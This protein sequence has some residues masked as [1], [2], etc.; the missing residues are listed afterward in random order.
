[1]KRL[2][3]LVLVMLSTSVMSKERIISIGPDI[4]EI[5][6]QLG[7]GDELVGRDMRSIYPPQAANLADVG[8]MRTLNAEGLLSL[9]PDKI[10]ASQLAA[11]SVVFEQIESMGIPV[12]FISGEPSINGMINRIQQVAKA[13]E[14]ESQGGE[15]VKQMQATLA[16]IPSTKL[17]LNVMFIRSFNNNN[18]LAAGKETLIDYVFQIAGVNN[19]LADMNRY[20]TLSGE[21]L[22]LAKPD[23]IVTTKTA[24]RYFQNEEDFWLLDNVINTP[25]GKNRQ[26]LVMDDMALLSFGLQTPQAILFLRHYAE[27]LVASQ[28][29]SN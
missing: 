14:R 2:L 3:F 21:G 18:I 22:I 9:Y 6:Y 15:L 1:M 25:A 12:I 17:P 29:N 7:A 8:Y 24:M 28:G 27:K 20:Q 4:T 11:P 23:L 19:A 5:I 26:L 16:Q 10:I 13:V